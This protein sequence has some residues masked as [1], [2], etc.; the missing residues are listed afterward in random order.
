MDANTIE[1]ANTIYTDSS[2]STPLS[3]ARYFAD[4]PSGN[5]YYWSGTNLQGPYTNNCQ[6]Q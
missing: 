2:C 5:Y 6:T 3:V 4:Q 1:Q